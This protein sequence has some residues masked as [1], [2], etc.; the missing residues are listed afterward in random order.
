MVALTAAAAPVL[1]PFEEL[2]LLVVNPNETP[3]SFYLTEQVFAAILTFDPTKALQD[4][5][6]TIK[7]FNMR[8]RLVDY[9]SKSKDVK[10]LK[11]DMILMETFK[12]GVY[13][14]NKKRLNKSN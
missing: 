2:E 8:K 10:E 4:S 9:I 12:I 13:F 14:R 3:R 1:D 6:D 5:V 11:P 7:L